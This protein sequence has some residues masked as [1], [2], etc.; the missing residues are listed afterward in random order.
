M[1]FRFILKSIFSFLLIA[2]SISACGSD[3]SNNNLINDRFGSQSADPFE[4]DFSELET[5]IQEITPINGNGQTLSNLDKNSEEVTLELQ[6]VLGVINIIIAELENN[7]LNQI[8]DD[9]IDGQES[10]RFT[11]QPTIIESDLGGNCIGEYNYDGSTNPNDPQIVSLD[12]SLTAQCNFYRL[13]IPI[14]NSD[15]EITYIVNGIITDEYKNKIELQS[16]FLGNN[17]IQETE[18]RTEFN[19]SIGNPYTAYISFLETSEASGVAGSPSTETVQ[20][21]IV[22]SGERFDCRYRVA[23]S[24]TQISNLTCNKFVSN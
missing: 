10:I 8:D 19:I 15:E 24:G 7:L 5:S 16:S 2:L 21:G 13:A 17:Y 3:D 6:I 12:K 11:N 20:T 22:F 23:P 4:F 18:S 9:D 1:S 14:Q